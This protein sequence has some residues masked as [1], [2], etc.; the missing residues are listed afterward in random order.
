MKSRHPLL[1][2]AM[3]LLITHLAHAHS[4]ATGSRHRAQLLDRIIAVAEDEAI[5]QSELDQSVANVQRRYAKHPEQL[6]PINVLRRQVLEHLILTRLELQ[7][8]RSQGIEVSALDMRRALQSVAL[9][10]HV[11]PSQLQQALRKA[12]QSITLFRKQVHDQLML[13]LLR[14]QVVQNAVSVTDSEV[15]N[16]LASPGY[17]SGQVHLAHIDIDIPS[18]ASA[19]EVQAATNKAKAALSAIHGGMDFNAAAIRYSSATDA[20]QGGDLGWRRSNEI[21]DAFTHTVSLLKIGEI[22]PILRGANGFHIIKLLGRRKSPKKIITQFHVRRI[23]I[24][25]SAIV[26]MQ[27]ARQQVQALYDRIVHQHASFGALAKIHSDDDKTASNGG[28]MG[29]IQDDGTHPTLIQTLR[30]L[31]NGAISQPFQTA[32]GWNLLQCLG[33]RQR[34]ITKQIVRQVARQTIGKRKAEEFYRNYLRQLRTDAY[35]KI[36]LPALQQTKDHGSQS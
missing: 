18:D 15:D 4:P 1:L 34:D 22:S 27:Q 32:N 10:N 31:K 28:D 35:V 6:P 19:T 24:K 2:L 20:L 12:G 3:T 11:T 36:L 30:Q 21:P 5:L 17:K 25:P 26:S 16:L 9:Q 33:T 14:R 8:A 13:Q 7:R 23:L 29:W